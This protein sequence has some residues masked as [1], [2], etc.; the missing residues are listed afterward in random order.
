MPIL[1]NTPLDPG[2]ID[3]EGLYDHVIITREIHNS[4][5]NR[6]V[7]SLEY[8][9][10]SDGEW[11]GGQASPVHDSNYPPAA[12]I[13][14]ADYED[15]ILNHEPLPGEKTYQATKRGLY[16]WLQSKFP[17]LVGSIV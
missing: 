8:G 2:D 5:R 14:G 17:S 7:L 10:I 6:I 1:L 16:Q 12:I 4:R 3:D 13:E 15:L 11:I 9:T